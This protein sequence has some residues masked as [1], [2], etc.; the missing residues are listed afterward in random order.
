ML[1]DLFSVLNCLEILFNYS[2]EHKESTKVLSLSS[3]I[4]VPTCLN[5]TSLLSH[6]CNEAIAEK[7][8]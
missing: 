8:K 7:V 6:R 4:F 3:V 2:N 5:G 1:N